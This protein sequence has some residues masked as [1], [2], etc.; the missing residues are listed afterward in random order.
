QAQVDAW[1]V[2]KNQQHT[3]I[4]APT[5]SGKTLAAFLSAIDDLVKLS[6][7]GELR[8]ETLVLYVS[9]LKALSNDI[10]KNLEE[11]LHGISDHLLNL[12]L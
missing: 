7:D 3:L 6:L 4:A 12:K 8:D 11:P 9:P 1:P 10:R 2:I 5:G